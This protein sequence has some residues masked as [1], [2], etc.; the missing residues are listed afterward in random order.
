MDNNNYTSWDCPMKDI[1]HG[2]IPAVL[3]KIE[4]CKDEEEKKKFREPLEYFRTH[5]Q[6]GDGDWRKNN[7]V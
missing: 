5:I 2:C 7:N 4:K 6:V 3:L 1:C